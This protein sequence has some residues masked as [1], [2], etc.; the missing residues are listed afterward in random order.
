MSSQIAL[1]NASSKRHPHDDDASINEDAQHI[2]AWV[3]SHG[4]AFEGYSLLDIGCGTGAFAIPLALKKAHITALD[5]SYD[6]LKIVNGKSEMHDL[7]G[8]VTLQHANW[9]TFTP[10]VT[11]DI[12][13]ASM[14]PAISTPRDIETM[15]NATRSLG[16]FVGWKKHHTN[17]LLDLLLI[18]HNAPEYH[19]NP[20][21][22]V[23]TFLHALEKASIAY[24]VHYFPSTYKRTYTFE[25]AKAYA[26]KQ[27]LSYGIFPNEV[28]I[29]AILND[30]MENNLIVSENRSEK[31]VVLFSKCPLLHHFSLVC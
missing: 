28:K 23:K 22:E 18:A 5:I 3:E 21:V 30:L 4:I 19:A 31:G 13:L 16:I 6:M 20:S 24:N 15:L 1:W 26:F 11:Y 8:F 12:V 10:P 27:L 17:S 9:S 2:I 14:T 7:S 29:N 25:Q